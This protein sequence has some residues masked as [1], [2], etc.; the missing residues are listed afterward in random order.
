MTLAARLH[1][2]E[3]ED[4]GPIRGVLR[5]EYLDEVL[6]AAAWARHAGEGESGRAG[7]LPAR[8]SDI[9][10]EYRSREKWRI[11]RSLGGGG[12]W[13][14]IRDEDNRW[15]TDARGRWER[16]V[17]RAG[18]TIWEQGS[19]ISED[20][21]ELM[22]HPALLW[23]SYSLVPRAQ[24]SQPTTGTQASGSCS[25]VLRPIETAWSHLIWP[26]ADQVDLGLSMDIGILL[27]TS[28]SLDGREYARSGWSRLSVHEPIP[29]GRFRPPP[30][31]KVRIVK[32]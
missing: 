15:I 27:W 22:L 17:P 29:D 25:L 2:L 18:A 1:A 7:T 13:V 30:E 20:H 9:S 32:V 11:E 3:R 26:G 28:A 19:G 10:L 23:D 12:S 5:V 31:A 14:E 4:V 6:L 24:G 16:H 21:L 8:T